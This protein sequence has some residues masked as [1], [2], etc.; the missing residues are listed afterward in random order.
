M[1]KRKEE[2]RFH[3]YNSL[4]NSNI[5]DYLFRILNNPLFNYNFY[6]LLVK[7]KNRVRL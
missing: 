1:L 5:L 4:T 6:S 3:Y 2:E 7:I